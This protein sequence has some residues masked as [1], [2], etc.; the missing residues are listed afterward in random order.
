[1]TSA[2][3]SKTLTQIGPGTPMAELMRQ[4]WLPAAKSSELKT[5]GPPMRLMLLGEMLIAFRDSSGRVGIMDHRC[6]HRC[7]SFFF[8]RNE[9]NGIRCVYH[10]WKFDA[11]GNCVDMPNVPPHQD[12][13]Q[14]VKAKAYRAEERNGLIWAYMGSR[15]KPP[16]L[17]ALEAALLPEDQVRISFFQRECNWMQ[18]LEGDVDTS[19]FSFL[20]FGALAPDDI[21]PDHVGR[22]NVTDRMPRY[23]VRET[24]WGIMYGAHRPE[25]PGVNYWRVAHFLFPFWTMPPHGDMADHVWTRAW[26]PLD[27]THTMFVELSWSERSPGLRTL[28]DGTP[29]PGIEPKMEYLP[30]TTAWL[31]R[32]R[33]AA[34]A[35]NDYMIDREAQGTDTYTGIG[36]IYL[37]DQA[38]TESMGAIT[39]HAFEQLA[40]SDHMITQT[41]R[42]LVRAARALAKDGKVP[43]G[44]DNSEMFLN[45]R[46]GDFLAAEGTDWTKAYEENLRASLD[47]TGRLRQ[48]A[49]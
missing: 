16:P 12:F 43:P 14:K 13:R 3:D 5:D 30:N 28:K 27:D 36:G 9:E 6:P 40:P 38:V 17:P 33:L 39:D 45:A 42:R 31:G 10:G 41:R 25:S 4:Y 26:V 44:V 32:W 2:R 19:H 35:A 46:G 8:G 29:I 34:N 15:R 47:P 22:L 23:E 48:A 1:M 20:H 49:E 37:Q 18:A 24:D 11:E 7:A 21:S